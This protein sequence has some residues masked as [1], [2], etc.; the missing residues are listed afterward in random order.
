M[1]YIVVYCFGDCED[2]LELILVLLSRV[3][4]YIVVYCFG[5]CEDMLEL[6]LVLLSRVGPM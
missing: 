1:S 2:M 4:T 6:I 5:D 3:G